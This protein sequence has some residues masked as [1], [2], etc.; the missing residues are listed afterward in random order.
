MPQEGFLKSNKILKGCQDRT[1]T[2]PESNH[3]P[4]PQ[5]YL[6]TCCCCFFYYFSGELAAVTANSAHLDSQEWIHQD[7]VKKYQSLSGS[8]Q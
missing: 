8:C 4:E 2:S 1:Q 7:K 5:I 6:D 3:Q